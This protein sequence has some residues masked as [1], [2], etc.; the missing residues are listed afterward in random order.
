MFHFQGNEPTEG[1]LARGLSMMPF[2][3]IVAVIFT[4]I[5]GAWLFHDPVH[6]FRYW[7]HGIASG[8]SKF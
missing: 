6:M 4:V 3:I 5:G 2:W 7:M 8:L 1:K